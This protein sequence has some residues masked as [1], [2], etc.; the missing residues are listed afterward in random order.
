MKYIEV[1]S[2]T[3]RAH[4][5]EDTLPSNTAEAAKFIECSNDSVAV[6]WWVNPADDSV[7]AQKTWSIDEA[8]RE[9]NK[10]LADSDWM[11]LEDSPHYANA[12]DLAALKIYRQALRDLPSNDPILDETFPSFPIET[13]D[14][15]DES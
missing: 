3:N 4:R 14:I 12:E 1:H 10:I 7:N 11:I 8:R 13:I 9:R 6:G 15:P 5:V 2:Q